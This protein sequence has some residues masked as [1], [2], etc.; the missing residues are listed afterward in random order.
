MTENDSKTYVELRRKLSI[1]INRLQDDAMRH[2]DL[3]CRAGELAAELKAQAKRK[4]L[5]VEEVKAV[6]DRAVRADHENYGIDKLTERA[7][8]SAVTLDQDVIL[9]K[10]ESV[11]ADLNADMAGVL[12]QAF[13]HRKSMLKN[14][15]D[16]YLS[17]YWCQPEAQ[18]KDLK[19]D[20]DG[21]K[22]DVQN[23]IGERRRVKKKEENST[24]EPQ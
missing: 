23:R 18:K 12:H 4:K 11:E 9:A 15:V 14:E 8:E 2:P 1:N 5:E 24:G 10:K 17:N 21:M 20:V 16:L 22:E 6:T 13:E 7:V 19:K 3:V